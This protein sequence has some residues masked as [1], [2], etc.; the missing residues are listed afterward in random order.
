M[1]KV[2]VVEDSAVVREF[3]VQTLTADPQV[4]VV[5]TARTG[6]AAVAAAQQLRPDVITMD[7]QMPGMD[8]FAAT[9]KIMETAPVPIVIVSGQIEPREVATTFRAIEAGAVAVVA[10][11]RGPGHA[12]HAAAA[13]ELVQ[14]VKLMAEVKVVRRWATSIPRAQAIPVAAPPAPA[15]GEFDL[16]VIGASTGGPAVLS[17][18]LAGLH[19]QFAVPVVIVQHIAA[20]FTQGLADWLAQSAA[21][22]VHLAAAD[23]PLLAGEVYIA[24]E[25]HQLGIGPGLRC[26]LTPDPPEH[27]MCPA[28]SC[29]FRSVAGASAP[30]TVGVLLTGMGRDGAAELKLLRDRGATTVVQDAASSVVHG[31]PGEAIALGAAAYIRSPAGIVQL[32]N[33]L[34]PPRRS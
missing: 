15:G 1:I 12:D 17:Q 28:V 2:L 34:I 31:M 23:K 27:G 30:R 10:R 14:T 3:L 13:R 24:P 7:I 6:E 22:P 19:P 20:G 25:G 21:R 29:L 4:R 18:I 8:G 9:R 5:G 33:E 32:L 11:P 26:M 16:V